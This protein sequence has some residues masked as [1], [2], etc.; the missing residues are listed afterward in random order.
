VRRT[1][2]I[3]VDQFEGEIM[4]RRVSILPVDVQIAGRIRT[5]RL[6]RGYSQQKV[7]KGLGLTFQQVQKYESGTNRVSIGT[8]HAIGKI[9]GVPM[10]YFLQGIDGSST[11]SPEMQSLHEALKTEE[12]VRVAAALSRIRRAPLRRHVADLLEAILAAE[13]DEA[14]SIN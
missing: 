13:A 5:A 3:R 2:V 8:L 10:S 14:R 7:A 9:L 1:A 11:G 4:T 12:G 6:S